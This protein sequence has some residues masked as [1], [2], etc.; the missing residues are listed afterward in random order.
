[1]FHP[2]DDC[3]HPLLYLPGNGKASQETAISGSFQQNLA[4]ICNSV[5]VWWLIIGWTPGWGSLWVVHPFILAPN[6][7]SA[8][9][10]MDILFSIFKHTPFNVFFPFRTFLLLS[11]L[12][13]F[14]LEFLIDILKNQYTEMISR[15]IK[16][17]NKFKNVKDTK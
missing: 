10:S 16:N 4:F 7:V 3:E 5:C 15:F 12:Q 8:T 13:L 14:W 6:F 11:N 9:P 17:F 1:V 2:I